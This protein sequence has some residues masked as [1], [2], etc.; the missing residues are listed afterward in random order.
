MRHLLDDLRYAARRLAATL[1]FTAAAVVTIALGVGIN[2]GIFSVFNGL[3]LRDLPAPHAG[4]RGVHTAGG[5]RND[6]SRSVPNPDFYHFA[7]DA[8]GERFITDSGPQDAGGGLW[9]ARLPA[10][11]DAPLAEL[12]RLLCPRSSWAKGTHIHPFLSPDGRR[13][14]FNSDESGQLQAYMLLGWAAGGA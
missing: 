1:G 7:T 2:T 14:F 9:L 10:D 11:E 4:H 3:A 5:I 13:A 12:A 6:L 8:A